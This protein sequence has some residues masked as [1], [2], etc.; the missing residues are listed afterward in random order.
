MTLTK[1]ASAFIATTASLMLIPA[2]A[3]AEDPETVVSGTRGSDDVPVAYVSYRG[4]NLATPTGVASLERR[5]AVA[6]RRICTTNGVQPLAIEM[7]EKAC[8][9]AAIGSATPQIA[10]AVEGFANRDVAALEPI[11]VIGTH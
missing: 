1:I 3:S 6:A 2:A 4:L 5:V 11:A 9:D 10:R 8:V 7:K